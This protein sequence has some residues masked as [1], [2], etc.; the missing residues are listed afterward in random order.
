MSK[1]DFHRATDTILSV[2]M[3]KENAERIKQ[4]AKTEAVSIQEVCRTF[5][6]EALK[7]YDQLTNGEGTE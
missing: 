7:D 3:S 6:N 4:I 2:R 5:L 1:Y